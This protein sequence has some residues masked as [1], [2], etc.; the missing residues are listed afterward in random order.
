MDNNSDGL[1]IADL[2]DSAI[3]ESKQAEFAPNEQVTGWLEIHAP[4]LH[5]NMMYFIDK[6]ISKGIT[7][8]HIREATHTL[9][10][11]AWR[12]RQLNKDKFA[13]WLEEQEHL[14]K[15]NDKED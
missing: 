6:E 12:L 10:N 11:A 7:H 1:S 13:E 3:K 5:K 14:K 2:I 15:I 9:N 8:G 4:S